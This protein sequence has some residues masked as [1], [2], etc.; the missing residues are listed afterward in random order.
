MSIPTAWSVSWTVLERW[1]TLIRLLNRGIT[2]AQTG[3]CS[4]VSSEIRRS[5]LTSTEVRIGRRRESNSRVKIDQNESE[6]P[7]PLP[8]RCSADLSARKNFG[9]L[10]EI[11]QTSQRCICETDNKER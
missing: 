8:P 1:R 5:P 2:L 4:S 3:T 6:L 9:D 7:L 11:G 10:I